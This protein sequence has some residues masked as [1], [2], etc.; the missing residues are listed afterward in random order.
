MGYSLVPR[1]LSRIGNSER[2]DPTAGIGFKNHI[3]RHMREIRSPE[4]P[5]LELSAD[6]RP[7]E[8]LQR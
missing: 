6:K 5:I 2:N 3:T 7:R 8:V 1:F 4:P